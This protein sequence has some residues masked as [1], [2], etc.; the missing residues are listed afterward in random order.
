MVAKPV[1]LGA[2]FKDGNIIM[3][4]KDNLPYVFSTY[5]LKNKTVQNRWVAQ[6]MEVNSAGEGGCVSDRVID[7]YNK[8]AAGH[9]GIIFI[10]AI[11]ISTNHLAR[12]NGLVINKKNL[13][14]YKNL[15][16]EMKSINDKTLVLFQI[17]HPGRQSGDFSSKVK[18]Y[19][20]ET[21]I[22]LLSTQQLDDIQQAFIKAASLAREAGADG[23]D[24]KACH[25]Y[26]GGEILRPLNQRAD[27]YG[28]SMENRA[29]LI[30]KIIQ[31]VKQSH[32]D[33][34]VGSR[35][36]L[37]EGIRGGCGTAT[38]NEVI[39]DLADILR[40]L[41]RFVQAGSDYI[42]VSAGIPLITPHITRPVK[43][44]PFDMF[45]HFRYT[46]I[47]KNRFPQTAIIGSTYTVG[48][49]ES[50]FYANEN[51]EKGYTDFAGFG[52]QNLADPLFPKKILS[53]ESNL[54]ICTLCSGCSRLMKKQEP[55]RCT[56]YDK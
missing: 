11:S 42:N 24:I 9:W 50:P 7:R 46:K 33:F 56:T 13:E 5:Q 43:Q 39:E 40:V 37:Y 45:H 6:A 35:V 44:N 52:R 21:D 17:F 31:S 30:E 19:E 1:R 26:L 38:K 27:R 48:K 49:E 41:Q 34:I 4:H 10:E 3:I 18:I 47:V 29:R 23:V 25:G 16:D 54:N 32:P 22:P 15:I 36:S 28:G 51:I 14:S 53:G 8:L 12:K 20:D 55:V 2:S